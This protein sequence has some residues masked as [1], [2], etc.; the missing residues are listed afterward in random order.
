MDVSEAACSG[1]F[2]YMV[3]YYPL[4][5]LLDINSFNVKELSYQ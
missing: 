4:P 3:L 1:A 5:D 2:P